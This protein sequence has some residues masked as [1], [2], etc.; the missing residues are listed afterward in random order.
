MYLSTPVVM[1]FSKPSFVY[2]HVLNTRSLLVTS[3]TRL[4]APCGQGHFRI[5][6]YILERASEVT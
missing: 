1:V 4:D 5:I 3:H 2:W 6:R